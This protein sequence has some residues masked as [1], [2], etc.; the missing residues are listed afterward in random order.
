MLYHSA[1]HS[2]SEPDNFPP[3]NSEKSQSPFQMEPPLINGDDE[4]CSSSS[5]PPPPPTSLIRNLYIAHFLTRWDARM[6]EFSVGLYMIHLWP[7]SLVLAAVYG[8]VESAS[9]AL[10]GPLVGQWIER[11]AY[12]QILRI[13]LVTQNLSFVIAGTTVVV[14]LMISSTLNSTAFVSLVALANVSGAIGVL[15]TLA[16]TILIEREWVVVTSEGHSPAVLTSMNSTIRRIDLSCKLLA[17]VVSGFIISFVSIE[18][19]AIALAC[20]NTVA[21]WLEYVLFMSVYKG[22]PA[23]RESNQKRVSRCYRSDDDSSTV[24]LISPEKVDGWFSNAP[25]FGAWRV[26][27]RQKVVLPGVALALLFFTVLR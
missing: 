7:D 10:F 25:F 22:V 1:A 5:S 8:A 27:F 17:P 19:S 16:G 26:Y 2:S 15:S 9:A 23:L 11:L 18:A 12:V 24:P 3:L 14:L 6:W 21:V 20:W 13:W 4:P